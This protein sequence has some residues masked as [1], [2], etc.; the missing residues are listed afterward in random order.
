MFYVA[1]F[2]FLRMRLPPGSTR[3]YTLFPYP[4]LF[5]SGVVPQ[6][7]AHGDWG[8][9]NLAVAA[10]ELVVWDWEH[11]IDQA[12]LGFD[13][14]HWAYQQRVVVQGEDPESAFGQIRRAHV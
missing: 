11:A 4:S 5:R 1:G 2:F 7:V 8:P 12:P 3:P 9:W 6:G 14:V 10:G 13:L